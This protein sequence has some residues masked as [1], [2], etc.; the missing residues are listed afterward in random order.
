MIGR[1]VCIVV[2][3]AGCG[4]WGFDN[5]DLDASHG[6]SG[7]GTKDAAIDAFSM[8]TMVVSFGERTGATHLNVSTDT[9]LSSTQ[10]T[11]NYGGDDSFNNSPTD[12]A[13]LRF[14]L[15][16]LPPSTVVVG[17]QLRIA[18]EDTALAS[19]TAEIY[20]ALE[21]WTEG[22][23]MGAA[24]VANYTMRTV[25]LPWTTP[26]AGAPG[27]RSTTSVGS[28]VPSAI[29]TDYAV[30]F[31]AAG[32]AAVQG[33]VNTPAT[34]FGFAITV[35]AGGGSWKVLSREALPATKCPL[36]VLTIE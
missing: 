11:F 30:T 3:V 10:P 25:A 7:G 19:G 12:V 23:G 6:D 2:A 36:L 35:S 16:A 22:S 5:D 18:S 1:V 8:G 9:S 33:W 13:L 17:A 26:G 20:Q 15:T 32:V 24:G 29:N 34:N 27:S 21:A 28:F 4:R 31:N 14:D